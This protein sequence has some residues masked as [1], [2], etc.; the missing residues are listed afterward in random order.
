MEKRR[1]EAYTYQKRKRKRNLL[2]AVTN[3]DLR[4]FKYTRM[5]VT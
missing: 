3:H 4:H 2:K 1:R 5:L